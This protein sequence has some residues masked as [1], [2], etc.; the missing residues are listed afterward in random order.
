M[1]KYA[2]KERVRGD[3]ALQI[4]QERRI[5]W[6]TEDEVYHFDLVKISSS[7]INQGYPSTTGSELSCTEESKF[8][9]FSF[10]N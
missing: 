3:A 8:Y 2:C 9:F 4:H 10:E 5:R 1:K 7:G 6:D